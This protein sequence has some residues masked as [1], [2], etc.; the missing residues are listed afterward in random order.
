MVSWSKKIYLSFWITLLVL[1]GVAIWGIPQL[2]DQSGEA[3]I[4]SLDGAPSAPSG[5]EI[6]GH[7]STRFPTRPFLSSSGAG[8]LPQRDPDPEPVSER[9]S[10][11]ESASE[12]APPVGLPSRAVPGVEEQRGLDERVTTRAYLAADSS[13][14]SRPQTTATVLGRVGSETRV[15]WYASASQGWEEILLK[16][17]RSAY[18]QSRDLSFSSNESS[19]STRGSQSEADLNLLPGTVESFLYSLSQTDLLR[20]ETHLSISTEGLSPDTLGPLSPYVGTA[21]LGRIIRVNAHPDDPS[22]TREVLLGYGSDLEH[23]VTT[24][25]GWSQQQRRWMLTG[26][27]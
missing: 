14:Y 11:S 21:D 22:Q 13:V 26:W 24:V 16:D 7:R 15:R 20:A 25:W 19:S 18:V 27:Y 4:K 2:L 5:Q 10:D 17:G 3:S 1:T 8:S 23:E 12:T 9:A 6:V